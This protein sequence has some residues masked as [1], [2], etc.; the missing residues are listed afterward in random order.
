MEITLAP[1][2]K[3]YFVSDA[4]LG[5]PNPQSSLVRERRL[6]A[7]L[8]SIAADCSHLFILGDLFDFWFEYKRVVPKGFVRLFGRLAEMSDRGVQ[9][10]Y[11]TGNH[12]MWTR[13]YFQ[14]ELGMQVFEEPELF[15]INGK[16][17]FIGHGDG[18][19]PGDRVYKATRLLFKASLL[20]W[21]FAR[22]HPNFGLGLARMVSSDSRRRNGHNDRHFLGEDKEIMIQ[23]AR[24][25]LAATPVDYFIMG[26]R[27][28]PLDLPLGEGSRFINLGDWLQHFTYAVFD[29]KDVGLKE[30]GR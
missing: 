8:D 12:D 27:H 28:Y 17:F 2:R 23:Y 6:V 21:V 11:F 1:S 19:G 30:F 9:I 13:D 22:L 5:S 15:R 10:F 18:L 25:F 24:T 7:W 20:R 3:I 26:H 29:G 16:Q 14:T 4:H